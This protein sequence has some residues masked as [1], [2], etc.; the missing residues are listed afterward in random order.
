MVKNCQSC[1][2]SLPTADAA[3][4]FYCR[5]FPPDRFTHELSGFPFV[6]PATVCGE[7]RYRNYFRRLGAAIARCAGF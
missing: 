2:F 5:R 6:S 4:T 7:H 3:V 1:R